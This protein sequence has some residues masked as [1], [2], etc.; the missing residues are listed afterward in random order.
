MILGLLVY[1]QQG[2]NQP[3]AR[4]HVQ[5]QAGNRM[6]ALYH[7]TMWKLGVDNPCVSMGVVFWKPTSIYFHSLATV[8]AATFRRVDYNQLGF[9]NS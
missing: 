2:Q 7:L 6:H 3:H 4:E 1:A 9:C 5:C 8:F